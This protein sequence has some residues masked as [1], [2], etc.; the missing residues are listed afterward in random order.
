MYYA[1]WHV[2]FCLTEHDAEEDGEQ[3]RGQDVPLLDA[4]EVGEVAR[5]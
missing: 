1:V 3:Y 4:V 2:L 5:R